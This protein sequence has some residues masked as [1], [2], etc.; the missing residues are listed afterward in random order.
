MLAPR[1]CRRAMVTGLVGLWI[2]LAGFVLLQG[3]LAQPSVTSEFGQNWG[4][5]D[6][7]IRA[8]VGVIDESKELEIG[9]SAM[10]LDNIGWS[11]EYNALRVTC[12]DTVKAV[13]YN[14]F[15]MRAMDD[16]NVRISS[17]L[18]KEI[19]CNVGEVISIDALAIIQEPVN[20]GVIE[21]VSNNWKWLWT[22]ILIPIGGWFVPNKIRK[23]TDKSKKK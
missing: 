7:P 23:R 3:L 19:D 21:F 13:A 17:A 1:Q 12:L 8:R 22:G 5:L 2:W 16:S 15:G 18:A 14:A 10:Q 9:L 4:T 20:G 6:L 11:G